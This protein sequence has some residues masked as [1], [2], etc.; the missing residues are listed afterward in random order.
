M[1]DSMAAQFVRLG[2]FRSDY[3]VVSALY[4]RMTT[5]KTPHRHQASTKHSVNLNCFH[6]VL[7]ATRH[8]TA[9]RT[10]PW[11]DGLLISAEQVEDDG[12]QRV[13]HQYSGLYRAD[14][15]EQ[16][17]LRITFFGQLLFDD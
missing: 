11:R 10:Q 2:I 14:N 3:R 16:L 1:I 4:Q 6:G 5:Q 15:R 7:R 13:F 9:R 12:L 8:V 17:S